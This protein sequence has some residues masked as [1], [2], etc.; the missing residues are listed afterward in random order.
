[1][2]VVSPKPNATLMT[3][4]LA[5][6]GRNSRWGC[7]GRCWNWAAAQMRLYRVAALR[8]VFGGSAAVLT[9]AMSAACW[10]AGR[11]TTDPADPDDELNRQK[12]LSRTGKNS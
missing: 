8:A 5:M 11:L 9:A 10:P 2:T 12:L 4:M 6:T 7:A 3:L 1:M